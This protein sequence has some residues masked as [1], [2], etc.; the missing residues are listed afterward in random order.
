MEGQCRGAPTP[1]NAVSAPH[2]ASTHP[3]PPA[4]CEPWVLPSRPSFA[5]RAGLKQ[6]RFSPFISR[7]YADM[8]KEIC[9]LP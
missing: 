7:F 5:T 1:H 9:S 4:P 8:L 2:G 3:K 6:P